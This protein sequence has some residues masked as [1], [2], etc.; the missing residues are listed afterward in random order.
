MRLDEK[1]IDKVLPGNIEMAV[2]KMLERSLD[3]P[4]YISSD[5]ASKAVRRHPEFVKALGDEV[6]HLVG[7]V[8]QQTRTAQMNE[9]TVRLDSIAS[10]LESKGLVKEAAQID[11][12]ANT[13]EAAAPQFDMDLRQEL[14]RLGLQVSKPARDTQGRVTQTV[15][16]PNGLFMMVAMPDETSEQPTYGLTLLDEARRPMKL[17][18]G[19]YFKSQPSHAATSP[20]EVIRVC[21]IIGG[22]SPENVQKSRSMGQ[23]QRMQGRARQQLKEH[24]T[25]EKAA[26]LVE[27][28]DY[29]AD[30]LESGGFM[31][32]AS[33][34]D[35]LS[36]TMEQ[37]G[38]DPDPRSIIETIKSLGT[39]EQVGRYLKSVMEKAPGK[40]QKLVDTIWE[41]TKDVPISGLGRSA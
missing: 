31:K 37:P 21:R 2:S 26:S 3:L 16:F 25:E 22:L 30:G 1:Y 11:T 33:E 40:F 5:A 35:V 7:T 6:N 13:I 18:V 36:N 23:A 34:I 32:E 28:L 4:W 20:R 29:V 19:M 10:S 14:K 27:F 24:F 12:V 41:L 8:A 39:K 9:I 15:G 17:P 38:S